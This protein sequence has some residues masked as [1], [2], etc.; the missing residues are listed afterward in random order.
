MSISYILGQSPVQVTT[1][2]E[3]GIKG[4]YSVLLYKAPIAPSMKTCIFL[5]AREYFFFF[6]MNGIMGP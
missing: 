4:K 6:L 2:E 3:F 5:L 1:E